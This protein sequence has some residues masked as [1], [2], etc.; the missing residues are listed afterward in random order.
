MSFET[1]EYQL[2]AGTVC[3][4]ERSDDRDLASIFPHDRDM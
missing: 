3:V 1:T 4:L 2:L